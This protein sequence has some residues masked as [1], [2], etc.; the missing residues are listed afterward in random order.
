MELSQ[1]FKSSVYFQCKF[2][3]LVPLLLTSSLWVQGHPMSWDQ[4]GFQRHKV[5]QKNRFQRVSEKQKQTLQPYRYSLGDHR[6]ANLLLSIL[7]H[8]LAINFRITRGERREEWETTNLFL[9][10]VSSTA[11]DT[12]V[13]NCLPAVMP[14]S[15]LQG[16]P[17]W[18]CYKTAGESQACSL[19]KK[20]VE[21]MLRAHID[22]PFLQLS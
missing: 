2:I 15:F 1:H 21:A 7:G 6:V 13:C 8:Q 17:F 16:S 3:T 12:S 9:S 10:P 19:W 14:V 18:L 4:L 20:N 5:R 11:K 22:P